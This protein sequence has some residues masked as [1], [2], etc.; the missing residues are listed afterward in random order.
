MTYEERRR[1]ASYTQ[2]IVRLIV[3]VNIHV[4]FLKYLT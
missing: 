2:V 4:T 3:D 1:H